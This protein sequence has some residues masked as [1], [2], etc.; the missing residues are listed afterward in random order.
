VASLSTLKGLNL[1]WRDIFALVPA[2]NNSD[3][4]LFFRTLKTG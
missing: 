4:S 1:I 2:S 3:L